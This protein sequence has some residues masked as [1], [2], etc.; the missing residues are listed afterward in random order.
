MMICVFVGILKGEP[1][2]EDAPEGRPPPDHAREPSRPGRLAVPR[3][4]DQRGEGY[5]GEVGGE[6]IASISFCFASFL[7][8]G[9]L[10]N[11]LFF[12]CWGEA[13]E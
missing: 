11:G 10:R 8:H 4:E 9:E 6:E 1:P 12:F 7:I 13:D 3:V 2:A 5:A